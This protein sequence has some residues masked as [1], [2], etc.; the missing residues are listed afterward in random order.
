MTMKEI[1]MAMVAVKMK[2]EG[3]SDL[4]IMAFL[5]RQDEE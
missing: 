5:Y 1:E 2:S 3:K 4:E